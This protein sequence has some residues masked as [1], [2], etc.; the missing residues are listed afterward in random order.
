[1]TA[2]NIDMQNAVSYEGDDITTFASAGT[3]NFV[4]FTTIPELATI[5]LLWFGSLSFVA[6]RRR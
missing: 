3:L 6:R 2:W 5:R 1:V 4:E